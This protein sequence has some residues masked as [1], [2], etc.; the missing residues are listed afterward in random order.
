MT[1]KENVE[2][3]YRFPTNCKNQTWSL[4]NLLKTSKALK[5][6]WMNSEILFKYS[7]I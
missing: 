5:K 2:T 4:K 6:P 3:P 1:T 7:D